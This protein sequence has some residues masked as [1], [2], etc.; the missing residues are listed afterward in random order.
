[1][2]QKNEECIKEIKVFASGGTAAL[3]RLK[4]VL[5]S[6]FSYYNMPTRGEQAEA[7][8]KAGLEPVESNGGVSFTLD[9]EKYIRIHPEPSGPI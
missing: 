6:L 9:E 3:Y 5:P 2:Q 7:L 8:R 4:Q 1:M